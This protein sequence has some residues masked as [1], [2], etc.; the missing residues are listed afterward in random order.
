MT[1]T[2]VPFVIT[3]PNWCVRPA[4]EHAADLWE[5]GGNCIHYS[6]DLSVAD[7]DGY[8][9]A[10]TEPKFNDPVDVSISTQTDPNGRETASAIVHIDGREYSE[11]QALALAEAIRTQ[12]QMRRTEARA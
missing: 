5:M 2:T 8:Q 6:A 4:P 10:L 11:A 3:C 12:V 9:E 1:T 7:P